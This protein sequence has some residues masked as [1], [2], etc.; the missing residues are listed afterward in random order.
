MSANDKKLQTLINAAG[1]NATE[2][3]SDEVVNFITANYQKEDWAWAS[4]QAINV[5]NVY[6]DISERLGECG[7]Y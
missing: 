2:E 5:G 6:T 3:Q 4:M 7:I 1:A